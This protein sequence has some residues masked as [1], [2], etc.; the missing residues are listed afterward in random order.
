[1]AFAPEIM[2]LNEGGYVMYY[3]GYSAH[4]RAHILRAVSDDGLMWR[5]QIEPVISPVQGTWSAAK[6]SEMCIFRLPHRKGENPRYRI[7]Y[8]ACDG[9]AQNE[10]GV[11]RIAGAMA[12][13]QNKHSRTI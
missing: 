9:T 7:V 1:M 3:A 11:W 5:K 10:R 13:S 2:R 8:E 4:N 12:A 6:C